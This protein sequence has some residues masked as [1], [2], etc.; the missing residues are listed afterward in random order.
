MKK[1]KKR[2][3]I[4]EDDIHFQRILKKLLSKKYEIIFTESLAEAYKT[5]KKES[6]FHVI[7][8]DWWVKDGSGVE[9]LNY[10]KKISYPAKLILI[11]ATHIQQIKEIKKPS[12]DFFIEKPVNITELIKIIEK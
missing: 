6:K 3:L 9:L 2:I 4:L 11:S 1:T 8:C 5:I 7:I 10:C 12:W